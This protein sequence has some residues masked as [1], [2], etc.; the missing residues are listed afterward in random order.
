ML[1]SC[2]RRYLD[3]SAQLSGRVCLL[4]SAL[5]A[6]ARPFALAC[7]INQLPWL[8]RFLFPSPVRSSYVQGRTMYE[9]FY[10]CLRRVPPDLSSAPG[11][12]VGAA[13]HGVSIVAAGPAGPAG[14]GLRPHM[15]NLWLRPRL[16][17]L[18]LISMFGRGKT[19]MGEKDT[20]REQ[21]LEQHSLALSCP[22][23][24][25]MKTVSSSLYLSL[26]FPLSCSC[27]FIYLCLPL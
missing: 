26:S 25:G 13:G 24:I 17:I 10:V 1:L 8:L 14:E 7:S 5:F 11:R 22:L 27:M 9:V 21:Y 20:S 12:A 3:P 23:R 4:G 18:S 19:W 16:Y 6:S 15:R 2:P